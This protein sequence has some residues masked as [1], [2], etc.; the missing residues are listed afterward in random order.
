MEWC[1]PVS[2]YVLQGKAEQQHQIP[3]GGENIPWTHGSDAT[4][5]DIFETPVTMTP[6]QKISKTLNSSQSALKILHVYFWGDNV[7]FW[8]NNVYFWENNV[9][10]WGK[11]VYFWENQDYSRGFSK[12]VGFGEIL[13]VAWVGFGTLWVG[14]GAL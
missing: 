1:G 11:N 5:L 7:Y 9:Y 4:V 12:I 13:F 2:L 3:G 6:Q 8:G 14:G 10:F